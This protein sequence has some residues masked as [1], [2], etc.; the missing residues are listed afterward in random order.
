LQAFGRRTPERVIAIIIAG[1]RNPQQE[2][3]LRLW[4]IMTKE[5]AN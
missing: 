1:I 2:Q 3:T 4:L 5:A